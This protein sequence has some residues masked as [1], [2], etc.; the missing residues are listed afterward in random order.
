MDVVE[1]NAGDEVAGAD[2]ILSDPTLPDGDVIGPRGLVIVN[3]KGLHARASAR[4]V[5]TVQR[6]DAT[7]LVEKDGEEV[8]GTDLLGLLML[9]G[10]QG[11]T[12][13]VSATGPDAVAA[14]DDLEALVAGGF[15]EA[16]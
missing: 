7:V 5:E 13:A 16:D 8:T 15:G 1:E 2:P 10:T 12:I 4:F 6:H 3:R 14:L 11:S 9:A